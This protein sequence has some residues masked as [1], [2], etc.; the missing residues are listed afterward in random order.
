M[1]FPLSTAF[2]VSHRFWVVV[3]SFSLVSMRILISFF[4]F[5]CDLL[6]IQ[7]SVVQP[8]YVRILDSFS[9]VS[10]FSCSVVSDSLLPHESQ[11][12]RPPCPS[13]SPRVHLDSRS[14]K[15][16]FNL[17]SLSSEKMLGMVSIFFNLLRLD[18]W[19]G[20]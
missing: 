19:P 20:M 16:T 1:N 7:Q 14:S 2:T 11:H 6:V 9:P 3:F 12:T 13:P 15:L 10:K 17:T 8:P 4:N 5:F 18:L